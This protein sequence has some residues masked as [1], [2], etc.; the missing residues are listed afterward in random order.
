MQSQFTKDL[1]TLLC[2]LIQGERKER[3]RWTFELSFSLHCSICP[4]DFGR[5]TQTL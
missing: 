2:F 4:T 1:I 3:D 5:T